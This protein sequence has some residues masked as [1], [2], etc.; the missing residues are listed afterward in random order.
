MRP[1]VDGTD[2][3]ATAAGF[4]ATGAG[5]GAGFGGGTATTTGGGGGVAVAV[6]LGDGEGEG[7]ADGEAVGV[8]AG[9]GE[10]ATVSLTGGFSGSD[11]ARAIITSVPISDTTMAEARIACVRGLR[12]RWIRP[13]T[14]E[15]L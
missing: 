4:G 11:C 9:D 13:R 7:D 8:T 5:L 10:A 14:D 6:G 15:G 1:G 3:G 12:C 2:R